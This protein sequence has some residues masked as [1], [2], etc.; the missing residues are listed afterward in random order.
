MGC[1][2]LTCYGED[3]G[4]AEEGRPE[5]CDEELEG[6]WQLTKAFCSD[7]HELKPS[8][9]LQ[10]KERVGRRPKPVKGILLPTWPAHQR[11]D[12]GGDC[13]MVKRHWWPGR[14]EFN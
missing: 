12:V 2:G 10:V 5:G 6:Q 9:Q 11:G 1:G 13:G 4:W 8:G 3:G 14:W 7:K